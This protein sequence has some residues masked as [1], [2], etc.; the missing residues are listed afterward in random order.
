MRTIRNASIW[1]A[2]ILFAIVCVDRAQAP[3]QRA[4]VDLG[5]TDWQLVK[6][7]GRDG[8]VMT[9]EDKSKYT[10]AFASDGAVTVRIDCNRGH[11]GWKSAGPHQLEFGPLALTRAMCPPSPLNDSLPRDWQN[12]QSYIV[13]N[14]HLFLSLKAD[15]GT[16]EFEPLMP[17]GTAH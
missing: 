8:K 14:S 1:L 9:P 10:I 11:G 7:Q 17:K 4:F 2:V 5:A 12:V 15:G 3:L 13:K 6:F 16:Y